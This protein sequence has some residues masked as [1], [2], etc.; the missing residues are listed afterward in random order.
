MFERKL[1]K[2]EASI[3]EILTA[4]NKILSDRISKLE[5]KVDDLQSSLEFKEA[6]L[7]EQINEIKTKEKEKS[8]NIEEIHK[9][10]TQE[11]KEKLRDMEDWSRRNNLRIDGIVEDY[12]ETWEVTE[13]KVQSMFINNLNL[14]DIKIERPHRMGRGQDGKIRTVIIKLLSYK[15]KLDILKNAKKL[16][17]TGYYINEDF[18]YETTMI[19]KELWEE[20]KQLRL[21]G[22][23]SILKYDRIYMREKR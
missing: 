21:K 8:E 1:K 12:D 7:S 16:K 15:D 19:R 10:E 3:I 23:Y 17:G 5:Q 14:D 6:E 20:V 22:I 13:K 18:S 11:L 2:Q 9:K 4:N